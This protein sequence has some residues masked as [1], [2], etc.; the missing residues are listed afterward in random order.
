MT[1][2]N[3]VQDLRDELVALLPDCDPGLIDL[4]TLLGLEVG[5]L[6]DAVMVHNAWSVWRN[7][8]KPDHPSLI[9]F[10]YLN[11][12]VQALDEPYAKAIREA[13][14]REHE[15]QLRKAGRA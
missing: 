3:Y 9:P 5:V 12:E 15:T 14:R 8:T 2:K 4:Y 13:V 10:P 11:P 1:E 6:V 7:R